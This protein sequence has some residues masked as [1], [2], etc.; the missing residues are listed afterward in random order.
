[1]SNY[2]H[3]SQEYW[4]RV[5]ITDLESRV[6]KGKLSIREVLPIVANQ[7]NLSINHLSNHWN[8]YI[9]ELNALESLTD[10]WV[11]CLQK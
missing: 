3:D 10:L 9:K 6:I 4:L 1:M 2:L 11:A 8:S 5:A 7:Y